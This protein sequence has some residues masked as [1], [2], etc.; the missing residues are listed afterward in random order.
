ME[1]KI[2]NLAHFLTFWTSVMKIELTEHGL[3]SIVSKFHDPSVKISENND[4]IK[5]SVESE[6]FP[7]LPFF[8]SS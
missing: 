7:S 4:K 3:L 1:K 6:F 5:T 8:L 2:E